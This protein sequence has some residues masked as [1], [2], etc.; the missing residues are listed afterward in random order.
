MGNFVNTALAEDLATSGI[1]EV[2]QA[3]EYEKWRDQEL[4]A[5]INE[6]CKAV[7]SKVSEVSNFD[8]YL[9]ELNS[10]RLAW[11]YLH[12]SKFWAENY[13][14][15]KLTLDVVEKLKNL[16]MSGTNDTIAVACNDLGEIAVLHK[17]GK[18]WANET[19]AKDMVMQKM[20]NPD[21]NV[22]REALLCCQKIM[23]NKWQD[24]SQK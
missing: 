18:A 3:L 16:V 21:R 6:I 12:T 4:Y 8:R 24:I 20:N 10:G 19:N 13:T 22:R 11:G 1:L 9:A 17:Q 5:R 14:N 15:D 23:L 2:I 7:Q